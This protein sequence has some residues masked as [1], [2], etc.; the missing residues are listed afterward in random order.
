VAVD[1]RDKR[2]S[3]LGMGLPMG[4]VLPVRDGSVDEED[5]EH[6]AYSYRGIQASAVVAPLIFLRLVGRI[7]VGTLGD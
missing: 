4:R 2:A 6:V 5:F 3:V 7:A 1:T